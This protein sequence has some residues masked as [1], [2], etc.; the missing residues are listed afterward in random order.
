MK[1]FQLSDPIS[2][3]IEQIKEEMGRTGEFEVE[4][5]FELPL[6]DHLKMDLYVLAVVDIDAGV[7]NVLKDSNVVN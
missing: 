3:L 4:G 1:S 2:S 6:Q 7:N 5:H